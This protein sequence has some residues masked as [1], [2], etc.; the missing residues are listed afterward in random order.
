MVGR[1]PTDAALAGGRLLRGDRPRPAGIAAEGRRARSA[2]IGRD[3]GRTHASLD[4]GGRDRAGFDGH[5]RTKGSRLHAA[6]D[7]LGLLLAARGTAADEQQ[8][9]QVEALAAK[10]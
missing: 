8:R 2:A 9:D 7:T 6:V 4:P 5:K 10:V 1:L 3:P